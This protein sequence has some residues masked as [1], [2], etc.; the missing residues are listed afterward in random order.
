MIRRMNKKADMNVLLIVFMALAV[1][2]SMLFIFITEQKQDLINLA[3]PQI[4]R[5]AYSEESL[6]RFYITDLAE[7]ALATTNS[8]IKNSGLP[9]DGPI[10]QDKF[11]ENFKTEVAKEEYSHILDI[12]NLRE[13]L[14][15]NKVVFS[16]TS[17]SLTIFIKEF[18]L[19]TMSSTIN[20]KRIKILFFISSSSKE[21][22]TTTLL[23]ISY[24]PDIKI[25]IPL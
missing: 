18:K 12:Q 17:D 8:E 14:S 7:K 16:Y 21:Q 19:R 20:E 13:R 24:N 9:K 23:G 11:E 15:S 2:L 5:S 1:F 3:S 4:V 25:S 22:E 10:F 6:A